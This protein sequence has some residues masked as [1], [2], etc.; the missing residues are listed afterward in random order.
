MKWWSQRFNLA[1]DST[2][3]DKMWVLRLNHFRTT[4]NVFFLKDFFIIDL[5]N[6]WIDLH[7]TALCRGLIQPT[8]LCLLALFSANQMF[9]VYVHGTIWFLS[10][11][12]FNQTERALLKH[13]DQRGRVL[14]LHFDRYWWTHLS[15]GVCGGFFVLSVFLAPCHVW[16]NLVYLKV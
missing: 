3:N 16:T 6:P 8:V 15:L 12:L 4:G 13:V 11:N 14:L 10:L 7:P 9:S 1:C 5:E 2:I